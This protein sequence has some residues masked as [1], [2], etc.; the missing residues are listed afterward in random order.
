MTPFLRPPTLPADDLLLLLR[1]W[2]PEAEIARAVTGTGVDIVGA[3]VPV[4]RVRDVWEIGRRS[5]G[6]SGWWPYVTSASPGGEA[7]YQDERGYD[8]TAGGLDTAEWERSVAEVVLQDHDARAASVV[9]SSFRWLTK[10]LPCDDEDFL[11]WRDDHDPDRL[12]PLLRPAAVGPMLGMPRWATDRSTSRDGMRWV[13]FVAA[14]GGYELPVLLPC[15]YANPNWFGHGSRCLTPL[16]DAA[17]LRRWQEQWG[18]QLFFAAGP[19][20]ELV[21]DRPP[22]DP[23]GAAQAATELYAYCG[24]TVQD[25]V[26]AGNGMAR[27]TMWSLWW[28]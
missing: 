27:S 24:D 6:E 23:R 21:V 8:T 28:D 15:L 16:D 4:E 12:A 13:N 2:C 26:G 9:V 20:L 11:G 5:H 10:S 1:E 19:Y 17:L 7:A 25:A 3:R 18:A 14:R 22:L